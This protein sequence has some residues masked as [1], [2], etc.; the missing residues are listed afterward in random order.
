MENQDN[1]QVNSPQNENFATPATESQ[2][3]PRPPQN[4]QQGRQKQEERG[5]ERHN[6]YRRPPRPQ[7]SDTDRQHDTARE[8]SIVIPLFNEEQSLRELYDKIRNAL[9]RN[10]KFEI[11]FVD[12]GSTDNSMRILHDLRHRDR[13]IKIIR[14]RR[15]YGKSAALSVGFS[16][17]KGDIIITMDAD[18]QDDPNEFPDGRR[19]AGIQS[20]KQFH[21][22]FSTSLYRR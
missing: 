16:H 7:G 2:T 4:Q 11:I 8:L 20:P 18:L 5:R 6:R 17:A 22:N 21:R 14:F 3:T 19:S 13:R 10:Q 15:N 1:M 12:D 9:S